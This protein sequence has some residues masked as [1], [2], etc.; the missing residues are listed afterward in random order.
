MILKLREDIEFIKRLA[1]EIAQEEIK[2]AIAE[3]K[4][5]NSTPLPDK[6]GALKRK[7]EK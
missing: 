1:R 4:A 6:S 5:E 2:K 7:G 3:C